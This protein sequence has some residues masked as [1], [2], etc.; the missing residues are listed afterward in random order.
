MTRVPTPAPGTPVWAK[1]WR[2]VCKLKP[3]WVHQSDPEQNLEPRLGMGVKNKPT[4][5]SGCEKNRRDH[6]LRPCHLTATKNPTMANPHPPYRQCS[7]C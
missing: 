4:T 7:P 1:N 6:R 5:R 3:I 2:Q